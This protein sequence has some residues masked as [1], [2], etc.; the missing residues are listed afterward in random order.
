MTKRA[1]DLSVAIQRELPRF[2]NANV[3]GSNQDDNGKKNE[4]IE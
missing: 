2:P 3:H 1:Q 4:L